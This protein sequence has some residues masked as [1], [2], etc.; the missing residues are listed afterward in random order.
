MEANETASIEDDT[1]SARI[2]HIASA[3]ASMRAEL[4]THALQI[5]ALQLGVKK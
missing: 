4:D 3:L 1:A 2:D 5:K